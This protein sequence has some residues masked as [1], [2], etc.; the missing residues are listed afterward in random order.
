MKPF[1]DYHTSFDLLDIRVGTIIRAEPFPRAKKPSYRLEID[2]GPELGIRRS[3]AQITAHYTSEALCGRQI[4]AVVNF[5]PRNIA[6]FLSE[7][8]VLGVYDADQN[9]VLLTP[10]K[11]LPDG[12]VIG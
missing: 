2:F 4:I 6:G 10:D 3:S 12:S 9:V 1:V 11:S 7:V 8:L 5:P